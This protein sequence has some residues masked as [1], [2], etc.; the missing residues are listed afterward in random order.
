MRPKANGRECEHTGIQ[1]YVADVE[2]KAKEVSNL[3]H[4]A[5][6]IAQ[7]DTRAPGSY[8]VVKPGGKALHSLH[9]NLLAER[10]LRDGGRNTVINCEVF[11]PSSDQGCQPEQDA[12]ECGVDNGA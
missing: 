5:H 8:V 3:R 11:A 1:G 2:W 7:R 10:V 4:E 9:T 6:E 12:G